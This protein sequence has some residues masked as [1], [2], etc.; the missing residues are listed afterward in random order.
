MIRIIDG[1]ANF[2]YDSR[3]KM[4]ARMSKLEKRATVTCK[5]QVVI[6]IEM[7]RALGLMDGTPVIF[8]LEDGILTVRPFRNAPPVREAR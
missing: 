4:E 3:D 2:P 1:P 7:R 8:S 5:G 6:P